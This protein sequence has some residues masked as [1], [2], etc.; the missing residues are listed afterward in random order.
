MADSAEVQVQGTSERTPRSCSRGKSR[1][2]RQSKTVSTGRLVAQNKRS[3]E[4]K[5]S[6]LIGRKSKRKIFSALYM[7]L[8]LV[9]QNCPMPPAALTLTPKFLTC[10]TAMFR[11]ALKMFL[12]DETAYHSII[13]IHA[14]GALFKALG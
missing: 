5:A 2:S 12:Q 3:K 11:T 9:S 1:V 6:P 13:C 7:Q 8:L 10:R 4:C 14:Y